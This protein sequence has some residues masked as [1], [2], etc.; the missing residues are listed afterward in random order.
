M[1]TYE[2][3]ISFAKCMLLDCIYILYIEQIRWYER[4][5]LYTNKTK[6]LYSHDK[7]IWSHK[8]LLYRYVFYICEYISTGIEVALK[9]LI[10]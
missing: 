1:K 6:S 2:T 5:L 9:N 8:F 7:F 3:S 4:I 10:N